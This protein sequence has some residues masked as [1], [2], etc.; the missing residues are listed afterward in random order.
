MIENSRLELCTL[1][2][3]LCFRL[4]VDTCERATIQLS[5]IGVICVICGWFLQTN[6]LG[7]F[8]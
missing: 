5:L 2:F 6:F 3:V 7:D 4:Q 8:L 1:S